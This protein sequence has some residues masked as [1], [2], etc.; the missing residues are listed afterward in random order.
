MIDRYGRTIDY[1]RISVTDR[2][3]LR[4][5]YCVPECGVTR[6]PTERLL[7]EEELLRI[8]RAA[9]KEGIAHVKVTGGE[10]LLRPNLAWL[11]Q[12]IRGIPGIETVTLTT[13]GILLPDQIDAL[14]A[15]GICGIN[16]SLDTLNKERYRSLTRG[17][18]LERALAG[19]EA[20]KRQK[21][22]T[23][24]VNAVL[25]ETHWEEDT[26]T[27]AAL[28]KKDPVHVRFIEHMPL[29]TE[30]EERPVREDAIL[31]LLQKEYG[32]C[33]S[34]Q[35]KIGEG[36]GH[37]VTFPGMT[38]KIGF[39]SAISHKFCSGCNRL[40]LTA[41]GD[42]RMCLQSKEGIPLRELLR[43]GATDEKVQEVFRGCILQKPEGHQMTE[44][45]IEAEGM[46]Q[47]GG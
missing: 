41:D 2:C 1:M 40:R 22:V 44:Q 46:C 26:L 3:N 21:S 14:V 30:T 4:C 39:I 27:L 45:K 12:K 5:V 13:N 37:Y 29:G 38:G 35:G 9:A 32:K 24:K 33:E 16:I 25:Y 47:I 17:G 18:E 19:L 42:L 15:A 43:D 36:P 20:A 8:T 7:T 10:P 31:A 11:V 34:Y 23:V 28:A 6:I